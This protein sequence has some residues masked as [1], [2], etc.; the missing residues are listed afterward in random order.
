MRLVSLRK[1]DQQVIEFA[2]RTYDR[3]WDR[4]GIYAGTITAS[5]ALVVAARNQFSFS[6][7]IMLA[8][9]FAVATVQ[10]NHQANRRYRAATNL[11]LTT[12]N[13]GFPFRLLLWGLY[14][15][16]FVTQDWISLFDCPF[17]LT[18]VYMCCVCFRDRQ[19]PPRQKSVALNHI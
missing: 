11:A 2:Q 13:V 3:V 18:C 1:A 17:E 16:Q 10:I 14:A 8:A 5:C 7:C 6:A 12:R 19:S 4:T 9:I 15:L